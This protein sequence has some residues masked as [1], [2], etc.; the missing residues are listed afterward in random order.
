MLIKR[1]RFDAR[2]GFFGA[3]DWLGS[4]RVKMSV[5]ED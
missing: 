2:C 1:C 5:C 4:G 3:V